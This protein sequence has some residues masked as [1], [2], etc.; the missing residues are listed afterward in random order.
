MASK[1][2]ILSEIMLVLKQNIGKALKIFEVKIGFA[3]SGLSV[4]AND[5]MCCDRKIGCQMGKRGMTTFVE[6]LL[7]CLKESQ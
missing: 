2:W 7:H 3:I 1:M 6:V 5:Q 4:I